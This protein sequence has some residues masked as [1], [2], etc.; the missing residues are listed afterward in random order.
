MNVTRRDVL[1]TSGLAL[2]ALALGGAKAQA[3][4]KPHAMCTF[5]DPQAAQ[6]YTYVQKLRDKG[7]V[8]PL[9]TPLADNEMRISFMGSVMPPS[10]LAQAEMS[11]FVEIGPWVK[12][13]PMY[14]G[15]EAYGHA[16]ESFIFDCGSGVSANYSAMGIAFRKMNKIFLNHLHADHMNDLAHIYCFGGAGDRHFPMYVWGPGPSEIKNPYSPPGQLYYPDGT[17]TYCEKIREA[18]R[19]HTESFSFQPTADKNYVVPKPEDWGVP[20]PL[21]PVS[22]DPD[23]DGYAMI[24]IELPWREVGGVAYNDATT[25]VKITHYPVIHARQGALGYK[26]EWTP[27]GASKP[28]TMI[29]TS[30]T[31]PE[32]NSVKQARNPDKTGVNQGVDVLIHE[33]ILPAEAWALKMMGVPEPPA[34]PARMYFQ[35]YVK[36]LKL[37]EESSHTP[38]GAFGYLLSQVQPRP[39]VTVA[40]HFPVSDDTVQCALKSVQAHCPEIEKVGDKLT[41]AFDRM[42]IRVF[43]GDPKPPIIEQVMADPILQFT[44]SPPA[45]IYDDRSPKYRNADGSMNPY[46]QIDRAAEIPW[47]DENGQINYCEDGY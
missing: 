20:G 47:Q 8:L 28:L 26:L 29:Y 31:K 43:A 12:A 16:T 27:K 44:F 23:W 25:G 19:W 37:I 30:D 1:K 11:V 41:W 6:Q 32:W 22:D 46:A 18:M 33:M 9:Y 34:G 4:C 35:E 21:K 7:Q 45:V 38:Q 24:P 40:C 14:R 10:R 17:R 2:G 36:H 3:D 42:V 13:A 39:R 15:N 5:P